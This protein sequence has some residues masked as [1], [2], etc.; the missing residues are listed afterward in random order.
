LLCTT[1]QKENSELDSDRSEHFHGDSESMITNTEYEPIQEQGNEKARGYRTASVSSQL[2]RS[3]GF[4]I[5]L[6]YAPV[7]ICF[8]AVGG[9]LW[10][11]ERRTEGDLESIRSS[12]YSIATGT[13]KM[14]IKV[15]ELQ[16]LVVE[17]S[18]SKTLLENRLAR[19]SAQIAVCIRS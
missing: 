5:F 17:S 6:A 13:G 12:L 2:H 3:A 8:L 14:E 10:H 11:F 15:G 1:T 16:R 19:L 7:L 9:L 18:V 4:S